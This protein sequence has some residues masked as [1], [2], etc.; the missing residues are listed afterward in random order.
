M[1]V[2]IIGKAILRMAHDNLLI[3]VHAEPFRGGFGLLR[4]PKFSRGDVAWIAR[5]GQL[6]RTKIRR[7]A[8]AKQKY[9]WRTLAVHPSVV[10]GIESPRAVEFQAAGRADACFLH[11]YRIERFDRVQANFREARLNERGIHGASLA[12][13]SDESA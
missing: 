8:R 11:Q 13:H 12:D 2:G 6:H 10:D 9:R 5:H 3:E 7:E 1:S 4:K